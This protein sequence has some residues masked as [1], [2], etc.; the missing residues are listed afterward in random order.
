MSKALSIHIG[1]NHIDPG[2]YGTDGVLNGCVNDAISMQQIADGRGF[3][4]TLLTN[5][6]AT[7]RRVLDWLA[8]AAT[9]LEPG[10]TTLVTYAGH[11][12][13]VPDLNNDEKSGLDQTWCLFDR[14]LVDDELAQAWSKFRPGV[15]IVLVT[16]SCHNASVARQLEIIS[17]SARSLSARDLRSL[18]H[19]GPVL[20]EQYG[21]TTAVAY[22]ALPAES[23]QM[24][25]QRNRDFY[26]TIQ[27]NTR[28]SERESIAASVITLAACPDG[29]TAAE[30]T[31]HGLFTENLLAAWND[32]EYQGNYRDFLEEIGTR[33]RP[34]QDPRYSIVGALN[35]AF[36]DEQ[37]FGIYSAA[38]M[39]GTEIAVAGEEILSSSDDQIS[40]LNPKPPATNSD[41]WCRME[42]AFP[43]A[44]LSRSELNGGA[45]CKISI[46]F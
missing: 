35:S 1:L 12:A 22:R 7:C 30:G 44:A 5:K 11:G 41:G 46:R 8:S 15:R 31:D 13:Q 29:G 45:D 37:P 20:G 18:A 28:G 2:Y 6:Q 23:E 14:M 24:V 36:A 3:A 32:G 38:K 39:P 25:N 21:R 27:R 4:S 33:I 40:I 16:D 17:R 34:Q 9:Q 10:D 42:F 43:I 19:V 26:A